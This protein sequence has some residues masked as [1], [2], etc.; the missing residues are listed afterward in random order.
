M[1]KILI[2]DQLQR[3]GL[4]IP[5]R[6]DLCEK[7]RRNLHSLLKSNNFVTTNLYSFWNRVGNTLSVRDALFSCH[8]SFVGKK[9]K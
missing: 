4:R 6:C 3:R 8:D 2:L 5:N 1:D 9:R 7:K